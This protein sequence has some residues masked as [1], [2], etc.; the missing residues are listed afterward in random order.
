MKIYFDQSDQLLNFKDEETVC[1][2]R[3]IRATRSTIAKL[4]IYIYLKKDLNYIRIIRN[5]GNQ[6][7]LEIKLSIMEQY[8]LTV[9][10]D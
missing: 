2:T 4:Y 9:V 7:N 6:N 1:S 5:K 3:V 8:A 10:T